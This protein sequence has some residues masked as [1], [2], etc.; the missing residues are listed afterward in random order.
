MLRYTR[1]CASKYSAQARHLR[2][3]DSRAFHATT[4]PRILEYLH[5]SQAQN[6]ALPLR[7]IRSSA[8]EKHFSK[9]E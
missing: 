3:F 7:E 5:H 1:F 9:F 4:W 8:V 6:M 2:H